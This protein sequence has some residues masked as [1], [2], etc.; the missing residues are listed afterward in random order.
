MRI[1]LLIVL[2]LM[3]S[4]AAGA[5]LPSYTIAIKDH[6][7]HPDKLEIPAGQ[8]VRLIIDNQDPAPEEF[9]SYALNREK[10]IPGNSKAPIFIGPLKP[11]EYEFSGEFHEKTARGKV[12]ATEK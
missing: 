5:E 8:K 6:V 10:L 2:A 12:I 7:F 4:L 3:A 1:L 11:G 9:D